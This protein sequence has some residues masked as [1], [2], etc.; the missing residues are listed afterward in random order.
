MLSIRFDDDHEWWASGQVFERLFRSA[1]AHGHLAAALEEWRHFADANGGFSMAAMDPAIA[2]DLRVGL[3]A[4]AGAELE[5]LGD[6]N[7]Q[8]EDAT[9]KVSLQKL[10]A[11]TDGL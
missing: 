2:R 7:L 4:A 1:L 11:V 8:P 9:Y 6:T 10:L 5:R 3:R